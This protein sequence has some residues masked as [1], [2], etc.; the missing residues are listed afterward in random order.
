MYACNFLSRPA[1]SW[2]FL[3]FFIDAMKKIHLLLASILLLATSAFAQ[4]ENLNSFMD[5]HKRD[6]GFTFAYLSKDLFEVATKS[7]IE[8]KDWAKLHNVVK[9]VGSLSILVGDSIADG[10]ALYREARDL[11]PT[12]EFDEL[13]AV[14]DGKDNVRVWAKEAEAVVTDLVL[15]VGSAEDFVLVCFTGQLELG[16]IVELAQLFDTES[17][18]QLAKTTE[19]LA[20]DFAISP[21]P[22][23][24]TFILNYSDESDAPT[25]LTVTDQNGRLVTTKN[26]AESAAQ[27]VMLTD[28]STGT[29]W[30]QV[31]TKQGK[32]GVKQMQVVR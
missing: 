4:Q 9:N 8:A 12:S 27:Q 3:H 11:V 30:V 2:L 26:L 29:Y 13:L 15:L 23:P 17:T 5:K 19:A 20:I 32:V 14:R 25:Q 16:N 31:K 7:Q 1:V 21:N 24:G 22:N 18:V 6:Q 28:I 10:Q